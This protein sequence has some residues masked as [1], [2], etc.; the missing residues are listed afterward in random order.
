M[1]L[2]SHAHA[3]RA[4]DE[5]MALQGALAFELRRDDHGFEM[6]VVGRADAH[7]CAGQP[8]L[9]QRLNFGGIHV[10]ARR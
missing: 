10:A 7:L 3:E 8:G 5:L 2:A 4:V 1:D 9:D 6:R